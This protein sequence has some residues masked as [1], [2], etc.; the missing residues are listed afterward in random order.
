[1]PTFESEIRESPDALRHMADYWRTEGRRIAA[2]CVPEQH[3]I[4]EVV[5]TGMG[6]SLNA[7]YP[8]KYLLARCGIPARIEPASELL[9]SLLPTIG[10]GT[11]VIAA[12]QSGE[13]I[14]TNKV[15]AAL[16]EHRR[17]IVVANND[18]SRMAASGRPFLPIFA[19]QETRTSSK[20]YTNT[21]ALLYLIA[22]Q[23]ADGNGASRTCVESAGDALVE[24]MRSTLAQANE[25]VERTLAH[26]IALD[27]M[28]VVARGPSLATAHELA[29][30]LAENIGLCVQPIDGGSF[31]HGFN[32]MAGEGHPMLFLAPDSQTAPLTGTIAAQMAERGSRVVV[33]SSGVAASD[34][35][36]ENVLELQLPLR[37]VV[38]E[39]VP[40][41][42]ILLLEILT[43]RLA[44]RAG[45]DPGRLESKVTLEE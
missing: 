14:E 44:E 2:S 28:Q 39:L 25:L 45:R 22:E 38:P 32:Y 43:L 27:A 26:W 20:T 30:I 31:R 11:L 5:F 36:V 4:R 9:Y 6:S 8:A 18:A 19:G 10:S 13:T 3:P 7:A 35:G 23:I 42:E 21:L 37:G 12:S 41:C 33:L 16:K 40:I 24:A 1:M 29:L 17:L 34:L 15:V